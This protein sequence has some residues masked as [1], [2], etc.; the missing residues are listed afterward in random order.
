MLTELAVEPLRAAAEPDS[1]Y[2]GAVLARL[3]ELALVPAVTQLKS[4]LQRINPVEQSEE[5]HSMFGKLVALE[6][7]VRVLREQA[8]GGLP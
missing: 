3:Q 7:Q 4:R 1:R 8:L 5:Y 6:G 2:V